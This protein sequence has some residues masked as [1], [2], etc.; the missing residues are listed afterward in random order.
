MLPAQQDETSIIAKKK[1]SVTQARPPCPKC[2]KALYV[3]ELIGSTVISK[4]ITCLL[5]KLEKS[6]SAKLSY[7]P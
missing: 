5:L 3:T 6:K 4:C 1:L 2:P 7:L